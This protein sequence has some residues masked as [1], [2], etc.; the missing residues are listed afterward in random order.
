MVM[1]PPRDIP[2]CIVTYH[3]IQ[4]LKCPRVNMVICPPR[5]ISTCIVTYYHIQELKHSRVNMVMALLETYIP[6]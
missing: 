5:D 2:T 1:G 4:E 3:H 6:A